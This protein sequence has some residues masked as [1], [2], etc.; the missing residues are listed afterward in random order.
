MVWREGWTRRCGGN[1]W[2]GVENQVDGDGIELL[3]SEIPSNRC[4][5]AL[6]SRPGFLDSAPAAKGGRRKKWERSGRNDRPWSLRG[7][8]LSWVHEAPGSNPDARS[9][10]ILGILTS[11]SKSSFTPNVIVEMG[12]P[13]VHFRKS[14]VVARLEN[15]R[16]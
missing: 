11:L 7:G 14:L 3:Q 10:N 8:V 1:F 15:G 16:L 4:S 13:R 9:K 6:I 12:Q 2:Q 5:V